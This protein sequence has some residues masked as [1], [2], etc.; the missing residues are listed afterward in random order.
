MSYG[1]FKLMLNNLKRKR[2]IDMKKVDERYNTEKEN[3][4][5]SFP[6]SKN[7][8]TLTMKIHLIIELSGEEA[9]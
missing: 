7:S 6:I 4:K 8:Q 1:K 3:S 9:E 5:R 2:E